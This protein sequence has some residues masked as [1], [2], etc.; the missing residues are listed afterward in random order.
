MR[1][2]STL[3]VDLFMFMSPALAEITE[4]KLTVVLTEKVQK[5]LVVLW[6]HVEEL[7]D[8]PVVPARLF[9]SPPDD[10]PNGVPRDFTLDVERIDGG[11]E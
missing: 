5:P 4:R 10:F 9:K 7:G 2:K 1:A 8:D 11:P 6:L 3:R